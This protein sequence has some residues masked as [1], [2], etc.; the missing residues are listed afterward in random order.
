MWISVLWISNK[1]HDSSPLL[2]FF[3][4]DYTS[5]N[6]QPLR[7][8]IKLR[9]NEYQNYISRQTS[10]FVYRKKMVIL[11][12][13]EVPMITTAI[14]FLR[15]PIFI[16]RLHWEK[17]QSRTFSPGMAI[18]A[19]KQLS[20]PDLGFYCTNNVTDITSINGTS[21]THYRRAVAQRFERAATWWWYVICTGR[22]ADFWVQCRQS[23]LQ[24]T[25]PVL[26]LSLTA[27][28]K[29]NGKGVYM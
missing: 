29:L 15:I 19:A 24:P 11:G 8:V 10:T 7:V 25:Q 28:Q 13:I 4:S 5:W 6:V 20:T 27:V 26:L 3:F 23:A 1:C 12:R 21:H 9:A 18:K 17:T 2:I 16:F 14:L 22:G